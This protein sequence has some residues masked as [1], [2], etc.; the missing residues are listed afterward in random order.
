[1][2]SSVHRPDRV[3]PL[4]DGVLQV[5]RSSLGAGALHD[6]P[7]DALQI[8]L[9][10]AFGALVQMLLDLR[11]VTARQGPVQVLVDALHPGVV[12]IAQSLAVA[13]F[14]FSCLLLSAAGVAS[15]AALNPRSAA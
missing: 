10:R 7:N 15:A 14:P 9:F 8:V 13:H 12:A 5:V 1:M 4:Q 3:D 2:R 11:K 6:F